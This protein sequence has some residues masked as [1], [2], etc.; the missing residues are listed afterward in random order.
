MRKGRLCCGHCNNP[1]YLIPSE[2]KVARLDLVPRRARCE[3]ADSRPDICS[4]HQPNA[5]IAFP[6][7]I[8]R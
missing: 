8:P 6:P 5:R 4:S 3:R 1:V 2:S 7:V